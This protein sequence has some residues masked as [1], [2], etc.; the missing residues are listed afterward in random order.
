MVPD[1]FETAGDCRAWME[2]LFETEQMQA[3]LEMAG[4]I[5][6]LLVTAALM[7]VVA[8]QIRVSF[9]VLYAGKSM[10]LVSEQNCALCCRH[11]AEMRREG[12]R[13][14]RRSAGRLSWFG[15]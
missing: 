11:W 2:R 4:G 14:I 13:T 6:G 8:E 5:P 3:A 1:L 10:L 12:R 7:R 15:A 9:E